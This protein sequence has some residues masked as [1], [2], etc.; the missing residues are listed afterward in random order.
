MSREEPPPPSSPHS[1]VYTCVADSCAFDFHR[2]YRP[3]AAS[4]RQRGGANREITAAKGLTLPVPRSPT[5]PHSHPSMYPH[6]AIRG[7]PVVN[8][9]AKRSLRISQT[10]Y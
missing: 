5:H 4:P 6:N 9:S 3:G 2:L 7:L 1:V 10:G 8:L